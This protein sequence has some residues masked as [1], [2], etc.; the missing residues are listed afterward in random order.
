MAGL[1]AAVVLLLGACGDDD[2]SGGFGLNG[3]GGS[4]GLATDAPDDAGGAGGATGLGGDEQAFCDWFT[5]VGPSPHGWDMDEAG[6]LAPPAEIA[7]AF[8][9]IVAGDTSLPNQSE[10]TRW[11][12]ENCF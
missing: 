7:D 12:T 5:S 6:S 11:V 3:D 1:A 2:G 8:G 4:P 9:A 10:V